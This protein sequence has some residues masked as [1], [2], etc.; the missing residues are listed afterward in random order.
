MLSDWH[1]GVGRSI[2][3][4][5]LPRIHF[6][7]IF[8]LHRHT[9]MTTHAS[10]DHNHVLSNASHVC[11]HCT[12]WGST[13]SSSFLPH[14]WPLST[15]LYKFKTDWRQKQWGDLEDSDNDDN[16]DYDWKTNKRRVDRSNF[17]MDFTL[18]Q[19]LFAVAINAVSI[20][21]IHW[22]VFYKEAVT[23]PV[24]PARPMILQSIPKAVPW[25][26]QLYLLLQ[27]SSEHH[28]WLFWS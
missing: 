5:T 16:D 19:Q 14:L 17:D 8:F 13:T 27:H 22:P 9:L 18:N 20:L 12:P 28:V 10:V 11:Y 4:S 26:I 24:F 1:T 23:C 3:A 25:P 15:I 2:A 6:V 21:A 7:F